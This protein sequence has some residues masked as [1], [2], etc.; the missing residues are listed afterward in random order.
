MPAVSL[1]PSEKCGSA[2]DK[3]GGDGNGE[4]PAAI[5]GVIVAALTLLVAIISLRSSA[6]RHWAS[7]LFPPQLVKEKVPI[8]APPILAPAPI[9]IMEDLRAVPVLGIPILGA[10][11]IYNIPFDAHPPCRHT[12]TPPCGHTPNAGEDDRVSQ[13]GESLGTSRYAVSSKINILS[14]Y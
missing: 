1:H 12:N 3:G 11:F 13:A 14:N 10:I 5:V 8:I 2:G 9:T 6:F 4:G 7:H